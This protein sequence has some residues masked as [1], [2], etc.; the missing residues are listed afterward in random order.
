MD[1]DPRKRPSA[2]ELLKNPIFKANKESN[3]SKS[4]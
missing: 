4:K 2:K 1:P 3:S